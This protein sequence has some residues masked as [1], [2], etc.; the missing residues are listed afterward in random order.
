M[1]AGIQVIESNS[2][3]SELRRMRFLGQLAEATLTTGNVRDFVSLL[4]DG[5]G[6]IIPV[7]AIYI[8]LHD[9]DSRIFYLPPELNNINHSTLNTSLQLLYHETSLHSLLGSKQPVLR[10]GKKGEA[11]FLESERR[12]FGEDIAADMAIPITA[13]DDELLGALCLVRK[14]PI[15]FNKIQQAIASTAASFIG[16]ILERDHFAEAVQRNEKQA[17]WWRSS[18]ETMFQLATTPLCLIDTESR[19]I[20][21][22][23]E[24]FA[25]LTGLRADE[26]QGNPVDDLFQEKDAELVQQKIAELDVEPYTSLRGLRLVTRN[27]QIRHVNLRIRSI[28]GDGRQAIIKF[29]DV[30]K[31]S[32]ATRKWGDVLNHL[33][34]IFSCWDEKELAEDLPGALEKGMEVLGVFLD[35]KFAA[36]RRLHG[37]EIE[38]MQAVSFDTFNDIK[39]ARPLL[40]GHTE[41]SVQD[42]QNLSDIRF[43]A[44]V[45]DE[46]SLRAI[47]PIARQLGYAS[48]IVVPITASG[49][50]R[51]ILT[52][53]FEKR[54][55]LHKSE[56]LVLKSAANLL[57]LNLK[58]Q[59]LE[60]VTARQAEH[61]QALQNFTRNVN[62]Y[63]ELEKLL[64]AT[65]L[66]T[67]KLLDFDIFEVTLFNDEGENVRTF[68]LASG[69][70]ARKVGVDRWQSLEEHSELGWLLHGDELPSVL[71]AEVEQFKASRLHVLLMP[72]EKYLG[73]LEISSLT[74]DSYTEEHA[75]FL[76]QIGAQLGI[77]IENARMFQNMQRQINQFSAL[78]TVS[79][80]IAREEPLHK[81]LTDLVRTTLTSLKAQDVSIYTFSHEHG[82]RKKLSTGDRDFAGFWSNHSVVTRKLVQERD[83]VVIENLSDPESG[84]EGEGAL[85][86]WP[87]FCKERVYGV[88]SVGWSKPRRFTRH[89]RDFTKAMANLASNAI[90]SARLN[91][92]GAEHTTKLVRVNDELEKFVYTVSHDLKSPIVSIQGFTSILLDTHADDLKSEA[93]HYLNRIQQNAMQMEQLIRDLLELSRVGRMNTPPE[94]VDSRLLIERALVEYSY[95]LEKGKIKVHLEENLPMILCNPALIKQVFSNLI[96]NAIKFM[97]PDNPAPEIIIGGTRKNDYALF[98]VQDNG[99]GIA[100]E[101]RE[102]IFNLFERET[103]IKNAEGTGLG[104]AIVKRII[105]NHKGKIWLESR[106]GKGATF[107]FTLPVPQKIS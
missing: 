96:G 55:T 84:E 35:A 9:R 77:A 20:H 61:I 24:K 37:E 50:A 68:R 46:E 27:G 102:K 34:K 40:S 43:F 13:R 71:D 60:L 95:Q 78:A 26:S 73:S 87:V 86:L 11:E 80:A 100:W 81:I 75:R 92:E 32:G 14:T 57:G 10:S 23:N 36:I 62:A 41:L 47:T 83:K 59:Q 1:V 103:T 29:L 49:Q 79:Y 89:E 56:Q 85:I 19:L 74:A 67:R 101:N 30:S 91:Q 76:N 16:K 97:S 88:F 22:T 17:A 98:K 33:E 105:E 38:L 5:L 21:L 64:P 28:H 66:E 70:I 45:Y 3:V 42:M 82:F 93:R 52:L 6:E 25:A 99:V 94:E 12:I 90:T 15:G 48:L 7:D 58:K 72:G 8:F 18:F 107:Y 54:K 63:R 4:H 53:Y 106:E 65:A 39:F 44:N 69:K 31:R 51:A 2:S 104:L